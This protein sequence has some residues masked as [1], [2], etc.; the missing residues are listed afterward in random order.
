M[1]IL[2]RMTLIVYLLNSCY[3]MNEEDLA[4]YQTKHQLLTLGWIHTHP[5][6]AAFLSTV[7]LATHYGYQI[8]LPEA[9]A[10]VCAPQHQPNHGV[11]RMTDNGMR[12]ISNKFKED[13]KFGST[14]EYLGPQNT[15][16]EKCTHVKIG[17]TPIK[18]V[19]L[20]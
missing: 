11:F 3:A 5:T 10:I 13:H 8:L 16:F 14:H 9:I 4:M 7:D 15:L 2:I 19:D 12:V 6:Q 18:V 17:Q 1:V 20:R